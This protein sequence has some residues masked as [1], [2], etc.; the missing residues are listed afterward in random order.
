M[1][2]KQTPSQPQDCPYW[3]GVKCCDVTK[4]V[5]R[6]TGEETCRFNTSS[7]H[8]SEYRETSVEVEPAP[9]T[10]A[11]ID[12]T[13]VLEKKIRIFCDRFGAVYSDDMVKPLASHLNSIVK[14]QQNCA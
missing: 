5:N 7:V 12:Y 10:S 11:N 14:A 3:N 8:H 4:F 13:A 9:S 2:C 1:N 6:E